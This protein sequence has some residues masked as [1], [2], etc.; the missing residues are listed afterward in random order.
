MSGQPEIS[1][2]V[3]AVFR[4]WRQANVNFLVLRNYESLPDFTTNDI[5]VL[6]APVQLRQ[7][8]QT[9]LQAASQAGFRLHN[10]VQFATLALYLSCPRADNPQ[11]HFDLF[12]ALK[13]HSFDFISCRDFLQRKTSRGLFTIPHP[14]H[15]AA[16]NL[17]ASLIYTGKVKDKYKPAIATTF[18]AEATLITELLTPTYGTANARFLAT[19]AAQQDWAAIEAAAGS[20]RRALVFRQLTRSPWRTFKSALADTRR[21]LG[22]WLRPPGLTVVLCGADGSG[23]STAARAVVDGLSTT[24]PAAKVRHFHWKPPVFTAAR[25]AA[26]GPATD[27]HALPPRNLALS[28]CCFAA[29]W[30]EFFLGSHLRLRPVTFR[31]GLVLIDRYYYDFFVDQRR[32]RLRAPPALV[33]LGHCLLKKPDLVLLLDAPAGILQ[34]RKQE[35]PLAE[36]ERQRLAYRQLV[37]Q[38]PNGRIMDASQ[39]PDKVGADLNRAILDFMSQRAARHSGSQLP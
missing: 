33:R 19:A 24:F 37:Q 8:E 14:A 27:P 11:A 30:L 2:L 16:T 23:K 10:R 25:Q 34:R 1:Q 18:K 13:W 22:R 20:L 38:L 21:L 28:L 12:T 15:E 39:P 36:T 35:V 17:L 6:V 3:T 5:D 7:A 9:L 4:A 31:G 26:R 32:Y 29:H